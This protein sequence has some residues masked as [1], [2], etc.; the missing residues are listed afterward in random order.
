MTEHVLPLPMN[1]QKHEDTSIGDVVLTDDRHQEL[2]AKS[3]K[4]APL[5]KLN[6]SGAKLLTSLLLV[7]AVVGIYH[8][9]VVSIVKFWPYDRFQ[10]SA[11]CRQYSHLLL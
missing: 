6:G 11:P 1:D 10:W 4:D 5:E 9:T 2:M 7:V 8:E 3:A